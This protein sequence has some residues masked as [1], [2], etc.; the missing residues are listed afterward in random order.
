MQSINR[1]STLLICDYLHLTVRVIIN[2]IVCTYEKVTRISY[3]IRNRVS[4]VNSLRWMNMHISRSFGIYL[5]I[6]QAYF[7]HY[8]AYENAHLFLHRCSAKCSF[9]RQ[10]SFQVVQI[11]W[12]CISFLPNRGQWLISLI[13]LGAKYGLTRKAK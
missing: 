3:C 12:K 1:F 11:G 4:F 8:S 5:S 7:K 2:I 13:A 6:V 9:C 10:F